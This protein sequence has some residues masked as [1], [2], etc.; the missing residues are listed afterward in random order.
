[1]STTVDALDVGASASPSAPDRADDHGRP[2]LPP[3]QLALLTG[4]LGL[5]VFMNVLDSSIANVAIPTISGNLAV[6]A[7]DGTFIITFFA[8]ANAVSVPISGWL[9]K[10]FGEVRLFVVCTILFTLFSLMC[11]LSPTFDIL[12]LFRA[13]QGA[14]AGPMIPISLSLLLANYRKE[15]QGF[16]NGIWGMTAIVG[17][18]A[19][20]V[21]GGIIT[22][23]F[24]WNW[25]FFINVPFGIVVAALTWT[26]LRKRETKIVHEGVDLVGLT[27]L[28]IGLFCLQLFLDRGNDDGWFQSEFI[29]IMAVVAA[30]TLLLFVAWEATDKH[31]L[32]ELR[33]YR[34]S[35]FTVASITMVLGYMAYFG[36]VVLFPLWL[37]TA[38]PYRYN[39][40]WAGYATAS[41][42]ICGVFTSPIAGRLSDKYDVRL[43]VSFGLLTFAAVSFA[44]SFGNIEM[45]FG[46]MFWLRVPWGIGM[47][48]F[49][50]PLT[51][52]SFDGV[53][54]EDL[55]SAASLFNFTRLEG[56]SIGTSISVALWDKRE[57]FHDHH[58][59]SLVDPTNPG[60]HA[61]LHHAGT[62]GLDAEQSLGLLA[63]QIKDQ[64]FMLS[65][66]EIYWVSGWLFVALTALAW[67]SHPKKPGAR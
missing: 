50:V 38:L 62:I 34:N 42:G 33:L 46:R 19:G 51:V 67:F 52:L 48:F 60:W 49:F 44:I 10:R 26:L 59:T 9:A 18:V 47:P 57:A 30:F 1:M 15:R 32:V 17:P 63:A 14:A 31:P 22:E 28:V 56:L 8:V 3:G 2:W 65:L 4:A 5:G 13:L 64:A 23:D 58:I 29:I 20:P 40:E 21:L 36:G 11:G 54:R 35:S 6:S 43:L 16:A 66:N 24:R 45:N 27:L 12:L 61:F 39:P 53:A 37:Q 55:A 25:I 41:L 7:D